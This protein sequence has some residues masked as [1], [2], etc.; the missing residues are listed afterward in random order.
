MILERIGGWLRSKHRRNVRG[1]GIW[2]GWV[3]TGWFNRE[4]D[5]GAMRSC[6]IFPYPLKV[7]KMH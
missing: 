2:L 1:I 7:G 4:S 6:E 3:F 5:S